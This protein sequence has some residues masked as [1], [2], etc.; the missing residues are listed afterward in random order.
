MNKKVNTLVFM[1]AATLLN[2]ALLAVFFIIGFVLLSLLLNAFPA[3]ADSS[4][5]AAV[6]TLLVFLL[7]IGLTFFIYNKL[8]LWVN[9]KFE[10]EDKLYPIFT[11]R[12]K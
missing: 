9:K 8:V 6:L 1:V 5:A 3:L 12:K 10:L 7:A 2:V 11:R 4:M